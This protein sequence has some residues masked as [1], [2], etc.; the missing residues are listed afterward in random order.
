[1]KKSLVLTG[2]MGVGKTTIGSLLSNHI[3]IKTPNLISKLEINLNEVLNKGSDVRLTV[4]LR[5]Q[6]I[7][8]DELYKSLKYSNDSSLTV[9]VSIFHTP[10][11]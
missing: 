11:V 5:I 3:G 7:V 2:M 1:M 10:Q 9:P 4:D 8:R 6:N